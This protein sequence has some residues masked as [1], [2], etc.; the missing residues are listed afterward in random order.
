MDRYGPREGWDSNS[1]AS[2]TSLVHLQVSCSSIEGNVHS[3]ACH[4][5]QQ[6]LQTITWGTLESWQCCDQ[7]EEMLDGQHQR[8]DVP[9]YART[10]HKG[11]LQ[12][13]LEEDL[14]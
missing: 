8:V 9:A 2:F 6:P 11:L 5:P 13:S 1:Q 14:C 4:T 7:Q 12:K 3:S 10:A